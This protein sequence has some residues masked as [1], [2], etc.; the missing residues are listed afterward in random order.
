MLACFGLK[1]SSDTIQEGAA[2]LGICSG[3]MYRSRSQ[4][5]KWQGLG[6]SSA[7]FALELNKLRLI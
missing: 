3:D 2:S 6:L 4:E 5:K 7:L 1:H